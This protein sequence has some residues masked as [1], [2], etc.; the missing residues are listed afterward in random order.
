L[1]TLFGLISL[2]YLVQGALTLIRVVRGWRSLWSTPVTAENATLVSRAAFFLLLPPFVALHEV[3]HSLAIWAYG[4]SVVD[5]G[6]LGY[7]G[8]VV[9]SASAGPLG[10]FW[11]ALAG[12]LVTL[13][14]GWLAVGLALWGPG[15]PIRNI[16]CFELGRQELFLVLVFYPAI[17]LMF[18]GDFQRIYDFGATPIASGVTA[19]VHAALLVAAYRWVFVAKPRPN[20]RRLEREL[21]D[22]VGKGDDPRLRIAWAK[23]L[24]QL[25][26][27]E[28]ALAALEP[29][30][31]RLFAP[32][33]LRALEEIESQARARS[34]SP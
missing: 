27:P 20:L 14:T 12:N 33:D 25:G 22:A 24:L 28:E 7:M 29:A 32:E 18:P 8:W 4:L 6:Y 9:P 2:F 26:R 15:H 31:A 16:L 5:W 21:S 13:V 34:T 17:C 11:I 30:R 19:A 10:D 1:F 3:G 23:V